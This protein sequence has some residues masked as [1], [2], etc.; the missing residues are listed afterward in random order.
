[1]DGRILKLIFSEIIQGYTQVHFGEFGSF[2]I[3]HA[4]AIDIGL[5]DLKFEEY[6]NIAKENG[7]PTQE[8]REQYIIKNELWDTKKDFEVVGLESYLET[9]RKTKDK[10]SREVEIKRLKELIKDTEDKIY[11]IKSEKELKI[12]ATAERYANQKIHEFYIQHACFKTKDLQEQLFEE[13][14]FNELNDIELSKL[15]S[16][17][18]ESI[19]KFNEKNLKHIA[20]SSFFS[21]LFYLCSDNAHVFYGKPI[22]NLT[23]YQL[24][25]FHYGTYFKGILSNMEVMPPD[26]I[27]KDPE[28]LTE[29]YLSSKNMK[30]QMQKHGE[31]ARPVG[32]SQEDMKKINKPKQEQGIDL[33][34]EAKKKGGR[35]NIEDLMK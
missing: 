8:D 27:L 32:L 29:W 16:I 7:I 17:F 22:I 20:I 19:A 33:V 11:K 24:D 4:N 18:N 9:L 5:I 13:D 12:G 21:N 26:D 1:M 34:A 2:F 30:E 10:S 6:L 14:N 15:L 28:K 35:L 25:L 31:N 23:N 3:K